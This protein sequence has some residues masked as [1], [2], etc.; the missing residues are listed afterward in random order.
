MS[1]K[2]SLYL[3]DLFSAARH[4]PQL[5]GTLLTMQATRDAEDLVRADR[6]IGTDLTG[7]E[8]IRPPMIPDDV[9][10]SASRR[11]MFDSKCAPDSHP[12]T[13]LLVLDVSEVD[14]AR[15]VPRVISHRLRVRDGPREEVLSSVVFGATF[16]DSAA[17]D[18]EGSIEEIIED[19]RTT[20]KSVLVH[21]MA[22]V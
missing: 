21:L 5:D 11:V 6:V 18:G 17:G 13:L 19:T 1:P 3:A 2:L 15:I 9:E 10:E 16:E 12:P 14:V 7:S 4:H 20:V 22:E 8:L